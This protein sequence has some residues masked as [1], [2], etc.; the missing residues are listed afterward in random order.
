MIG[1]VIYLAIGRTREGCGDPAPTGIRRVAATTVLSHAG[2]AATL[3]LPMAEFSI[4]RFVDRYARR[5]AGMS[6]SE[7]RA[8]FAVA[9]RPDVVSLAGGMP[10][11]Q[12]LPDRGRR[13]RSSARSSTSTGPIALQYGGGQGHPALRERLV[14]LMAEE[15]VEAD[16]DDVVVTTGAQQALDLVGKI[17]ID[18]GDL[19]AVEAPAYV[20]ALTAFSAY[21]PRYLQIELDDDGMVVDRLEEA[22]RRAATR[23]KFVYTVPELRQP[24]RCD[25]VIRAAASGSSRSAARRASRSSRTTRTACCGSRATRSRACGPSTPRT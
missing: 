22:L 25:D 12:A 17:F 9:S 5:T 8:L 1:A 4:D 7:V 23:P 24:R 6:A 18:P 13:S 11:V 2:P 16:P 20:G 19:I 15:G 21:E 3:S 14:A 10:F